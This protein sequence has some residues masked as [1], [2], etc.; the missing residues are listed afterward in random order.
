MNYLFFT[1]KTF[2]Q[3]EFKNNANAIAHA[4]SSSEIIKCIASKGSV[5]VY[6]KPKIEETNE[7]PKPKPNLA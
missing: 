1:D 5:V 2:T 4:K 7:Q 3:K 6:Q